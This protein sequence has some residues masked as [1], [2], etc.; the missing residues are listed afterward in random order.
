MNRLRALGG[1]RIIKENAGYAVGIA[2]AYPGRAF[3]ITLFM[4]GA[5]LVVVGGRA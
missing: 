3:S 5:T 2:V 4:I 1:R